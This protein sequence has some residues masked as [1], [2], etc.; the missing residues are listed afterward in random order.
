MACHSSPKNS[1]LDLSRPAEVP[2]KDTKGMGHLLL[3]PWE[4][5]SSVVGAGL[6]FRSWPPGTVGSQA[7]LPQ[8]RDA[9]SPDTKRV[10]RAEQARLGD[11][12]R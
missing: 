6:E 4:L 7:E 11:R 10:L 2:F 1:S 9:H 5:A 12:Q 8:T 3:V